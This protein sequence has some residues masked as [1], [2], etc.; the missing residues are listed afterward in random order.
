M[1]VGLGVFV[2]IGLGTAGGPGLAVFVGAGVFVGP[3]LAVFVGAGVFV[4]PGFAVFVGLGVF[5]GV[6]V[7]VAVGVFVGLG[8]GVCSPQSSCR[9]PSENGIPS[10]MQSWYIPRAPAVFVCPSARKTVRTRSGTRALAVQYWTILDAFLP[11][12]EWGTGRPAWDS[13]CSL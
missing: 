2:A 10:T 3:G 4:G 12:G 5:V 8:V 11:Y 7:L 1:C 9:G 6:G 13:L